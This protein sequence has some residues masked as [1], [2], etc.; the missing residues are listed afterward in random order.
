[1]RKIDVKAAI[2]QKYKG[3]LPWFVVR[4]LER[5]IHQD[6]LNEIMALQDHVGGVE[7]ARR[8]MNEMN[9]TTEVIGAERLP[10][11]GERVLF[12]C[13]HPLGG[14]DGIILTGLL[15]EHYD[16]KIRVMVNDVL[17]NV[18]QFEDVFVPVN[19]YGSQGRKHLSTMEEAL[20]SDNQILTF[21]AG[22]CSRSNENGYICD[23]PW[24]SSFVKMAHRH[25]RMVVPLFF[26]GVNSPKF[27]KWAKRRK[28]MGIK[29]NYELIL[30]P[31]ELL[32]AKGKHFRIFVGE[33]IK[34]SDLPKGKDIN[35]FVESIQKE[36]YTYPDK[37]TGNKACVLQQL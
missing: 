28:N 12:V 18:F 24:R 13:N 33:P 22:F 34:V 31:Q 4:W 2:R 11:K 37:Y 32:K 14:A 15:G 30:L 20:E 35:A 21:P 9:I 36:I 5:I 3:F 25:D 17:L 26:D 27:Y 1:M 16:G 7:M 29:F 6:E 10:S 19:K 23:I 8:V